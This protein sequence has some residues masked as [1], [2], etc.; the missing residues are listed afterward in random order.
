MRFLFAFLIFLQKVFAL[1]LNRTFSFFKKVFA[2]KIFAILAHKKL[3]PEFYSQMI[4]CQNFI[5]SMHPTPS[6]RVFDAELSYIWQ[7]VGL[8]LQYDLLSEKFVLFLSAVFF[9]NILF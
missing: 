6:N 8:P 7:L 2:G 5:A 1:N 9:V 4:F 3:S